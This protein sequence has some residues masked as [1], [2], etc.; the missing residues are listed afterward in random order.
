MK[1]SKLN[2]ELIAYAASFISF[3]LP[4]IDV[5]EIIL[6]GSVSREE[7]TKESDVDLFLI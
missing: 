7:A 6:F 5:D 2:K 1:T 4:K 3:I